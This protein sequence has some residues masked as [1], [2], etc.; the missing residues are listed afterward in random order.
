MNEKLNPFGLIQR[1]EKFFE[2]SEKII[3]SFKIKANIEVA[4]EEE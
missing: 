3:Q 2:N 4:M 1:D